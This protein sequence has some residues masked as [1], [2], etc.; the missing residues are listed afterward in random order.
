MQIAK[1]SD[2]DME[3]AMIIA[4]ML[5]DVDR[6]FFPRG[7]DGECDDDDPVHFDQDNADHLKAF[8]DR[9]MSAYDMAPGG[10]NRVVLGFHTIMHNDVVDPGKDHLA[11]HPRLEAALESIKDSEE[12]LLP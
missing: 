3:V 6:G 8:H 1:A 4:G 11:F 5:C 9:I 2:R 7:P 12:E 10:M